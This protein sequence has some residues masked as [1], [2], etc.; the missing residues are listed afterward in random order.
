MIIGIVIGSGIFKS[1]NILIA[2]GGNVVPGVII[3]VAAVSTLFLKSDGGGEAGLPTDDEPGGGASTYARVFINPMRVR[4]TAGFP[5]LCSYLPTITVV[6][7]CFAF[8]LWA[9]NINARR[10]SF[11]GKPWVSAFAGLCP[12]HIYSVSLAGLFQNAA[13]VIKLI[14]TSD[15]VMAAGLFIGNTGN[16]Q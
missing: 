3:S 9:F 1:D 12:M 10:W 13:T 2:T 6:L 15:R 11:S 16:R 8:T 14:S 7:S 4:P 5:T